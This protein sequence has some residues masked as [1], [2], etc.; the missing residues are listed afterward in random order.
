MRDNALVAAL[1]RRGCEASL[2]PLYLPMMLDEADETDCPLFFGGINTFLQ[3][4][5]G[6]FRHT[7]RWFDSLLD[8]KALLNWSAQFQHMTRPIDLGVLTL[9]MLKAEEGHQAKELRRLTRWLKDQPPH[10]AICLSNLLLAGMARQLKAELKIPVI[11]TMQGE[12][13]FLDDLPEEYGKEA[14]ALLAKRCEDCDA[15]IAVSRYYE[16]VM[17]H[18]L[19]LPGDRVHTVHNGISIRGYEPASTPPSR[20]TVGYLARFCPPK[21]LHL[22]VDA[23]IELR[24]QGVHDDLDLLLVGSC[25]RGDRSYL[26]EQEGKLRRAG[27]LDQVRIHANVGLH[28]KQELLRRMTLLSVPACYGEAFGLYLLEALASNV[29]VVQPRR[30][31]FEEIVKATG[32]GWLY[33][34]DDKRCEAALLAE[35]LDRALKDEGERR[36]RAGQGRRAVVERFSIETMAASVSAVYDQVIEA[37]RKSNQ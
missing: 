5:S 3:E 25:T 17:T 8:R 36:K 34:V 15:F 29:P 30:G 32:G 18:R 14:W 23:Y 10:D 26:Q 20:K 13:T 9:G 21:G 19:S 28:E 24:R 6:F 7:P 33:D 37:S 1:R 12:D 4:K 31:A 11:C 22:L 16:E 35:C 2:L 27:L